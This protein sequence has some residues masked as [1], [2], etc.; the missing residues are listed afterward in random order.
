MSL[1]IFEKHFSEID[2]YFEIQVN[3]DWMRPFDQE[4]LA[5]TIAFQS[6]AVIADSSRY[7]WEV[8]ALSASKKFHVSKKYIRN[9]TC[10][11]E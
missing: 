5:H 4:L 8:L 11:R 9:S 3:Y 6:S 10:R 7:C 1:L 2:T